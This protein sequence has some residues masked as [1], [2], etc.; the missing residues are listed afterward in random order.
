MIVASLRPDS[1]PSQLPVPLSASPGRGLD[2]GDLA[3]MV[4]KR[5]AG[6]T[7]LKAYMHCIY[8]P[9]QTAPEMQTDSARLSPRLAAKLNLN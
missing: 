5:F 2:I 9:F 8:G 1:V 3:Q 6:K 7:M 4:P